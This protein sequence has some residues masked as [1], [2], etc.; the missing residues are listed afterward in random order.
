MARIIFKLKQGGLREWATLPNGSRRYWED[1]ESHAKEVVR[2]PQRLEAFMAYYG[3]LQD[4]LGDQ[5]PMKTEVLDI[6]GKV[7][8]NSFN[9]MNEDYQS[10]GIGLYLSASII[11]HSCNPNATTTFQGHNL[12]L[13][14]IRDVADFADIRISY[15]HLLGKIKH[16]MASYKSFTKSRFSTYQSKETNPP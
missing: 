4:C 15:T 12:I 8:I 1:L 5:L 3:V 9:I 2:D 16:C 14:T 11:D 6:F 13:R 7:V 10:V